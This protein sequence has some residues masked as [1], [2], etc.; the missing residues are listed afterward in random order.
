MDAT[1]FWKSVWN[2]FLATV[3]DRVSGTAIEE[4][5]KNEIILVVLESLKKSKEAVYSEYSSVMTFRDLVNDEIRKKHPW[6]IISNF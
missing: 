2:D 1:F 6:L 5:E 4:M 3:N